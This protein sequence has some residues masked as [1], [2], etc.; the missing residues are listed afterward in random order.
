L[1]SAKKKKLILNADDYGLSPLFNKGI[2][3]LARKKLSA[4]PR[5]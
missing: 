4:A 2:L 3:E 5:S 1:I